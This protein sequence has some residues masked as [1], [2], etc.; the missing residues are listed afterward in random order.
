MGRG[1]SGARAQRS[2]VGGGDGK[3]CVVERE[4]E[5][6]TKI[7]VRVDG[8]GL[9]RGGG[10]QAGWKSAVRVV[11]GWMRDRVGRAHG[12][13]G[14]KNVGGGG[15]GVTTAVG[16][17]LGRRGRHRLF[18]SDPLFHRIY[19]RA[20]AKSSVQDRTYLRLNQPI[21][22]VVLGPHQANVGDL[23]ALRV[24]PPRQSSAASPWCERHG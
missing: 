7:Q 13:G 1:P 9:G 4:V 10:R 23:I 21:R 16:N 15:M 20:H 6:G 12:C 19:V 2:R 18:P 11:S 24:A 14:W 17:G 3:P 22:R 5:M 8:V